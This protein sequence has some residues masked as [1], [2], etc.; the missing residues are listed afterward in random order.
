MK[1]LQVVLTSL[2]FSGCVTGYNP[3]YF[4]N[5]IQVVNLSGETIADVN[6]RVGGSGRTLACAEVKSNAMC[7][8]RFGKR[9]YPQGKLDLSWTGGDGKRRSQQAAPS[10]PAYF[11]SAFALRVVMEIKPDGSINAFFEQDEPGRDDGFLI[12]GS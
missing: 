10:A 8:E 5:E 9:R 4:Y 12:I 7:S 3:S 1:T 2:L 11:P 6:L